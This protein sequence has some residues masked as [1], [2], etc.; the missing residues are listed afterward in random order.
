MLKLTD[1]TEEYA[2]SWNCALVQHTNITVLAYLISPPY[3]GYFF[4]FWCQLTIYM[5]AVAEL[6]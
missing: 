4:F 3:C 6:Q 2:D 5:N 1:S